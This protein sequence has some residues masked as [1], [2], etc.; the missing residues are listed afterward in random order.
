M[1]LETRS[2]EIK[3]TKT[4]IDSRR[5]EVRDYFILLTRCSVNI[6]Y[7]TLLAELLKCLRLYDYVS[8]K[9][10][11]VIFEYNIIYM[12]IYITHMHAHTHTHTR[13]HARTHAYTYT[14]PLKNLEIIENL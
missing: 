14:K 7:E 2:N 10:F 9:F 5:T 11:N 12:Y 6:I 1:A 3:S 13:M 8:L 4:S